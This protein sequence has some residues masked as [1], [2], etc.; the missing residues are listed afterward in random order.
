MAVRL[1]VKPRNGDGLA[2][3]WDHIASAKP[4]VTG[5]AMRAVAG[6]A[7]SNGRLPWE[8]VTRY[9]ND[10]VAYT[11]T[12]YGT[13]VAWLTLA[14]EWRVPATSY[15]RTTGIHQSRVRSALTWAGI[16]YVEEV[17]GVDALRVA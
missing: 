9:R 1:A 7:Y 3:L 2:R 13:P 8:W 4:F 14:G 10:D 5:G 11:V 12:S 17:T 15:S 16:E 6:R